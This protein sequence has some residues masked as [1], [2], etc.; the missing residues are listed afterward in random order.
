MNRLRCND[1]LSI[2]FRKR[3]HNAVKRVG[4]VLRTRLV[5]ENGVPIFLGVQRFLIAE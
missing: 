5:L 1:R 2:L 3:D 4:T